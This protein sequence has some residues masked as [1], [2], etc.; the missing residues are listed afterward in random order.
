MMT[1]SSADR[2][3]VTEFG[4]SEDSQALAFRAPVKS[5]VPQRDRE[6]LACSLNFIQ[7]PPGPLTL[8][9]IPS[10]RNRPL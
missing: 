6:E 4:F 9:T 7:P 10:R 5:A 1:L 2:T 8:Q 3:H